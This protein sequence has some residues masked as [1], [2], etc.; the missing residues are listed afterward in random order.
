MSLGNTGDSLGQP[1]PGQPSAPGSAD[2]ASP[3][4]GQRHPLQR[5]AAQTRAG[6][7]LNGLVKEMNNA[8]QTSDVS[9]PSGLSRGD[10]PLCLCLKTKPNLVVDL[11]VSVS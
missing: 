9:L 3:A 4:A 10:G 1:G 6:S 7:P 8:D 2:A 11:Q 5:E